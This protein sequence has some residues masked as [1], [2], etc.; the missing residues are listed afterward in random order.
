MIRVITALLA[1]VVISLFVGGLAYSIWE[2]TESIA[3]PV[4]VALVLVMVYVAIIQE[5]R[6]GDDNT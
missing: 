5:L 4:I 3:F 6:S 1:M 2:N